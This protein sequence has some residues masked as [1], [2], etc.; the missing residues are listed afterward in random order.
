VESRYNNASSLTIFSN[1]GEGNSC[2]S[3]AN[4]H[5]IASN[6]GQ[7]FSISLFKSLKIFDLPKYRV[8]GTTVHKP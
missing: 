2:S 6:N 1:H 3:R 7:N 8:C 5:R 4:Y